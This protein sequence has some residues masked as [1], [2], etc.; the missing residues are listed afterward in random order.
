MKS[1][2]RSMAIIVIAVSLMLVGRNRLEM[3]RGV[4][5]DKVV[6]FYNWGDYIDPELLKQFEEETGY[7]VVYETFDSNEAMVTKIQQGG[8][9]YDLIGPSEYMVESMVE[10]G[11]LLPINKDLLP[12]LVNIDPKFMDQAYDPGNKYSIPYFWGTLG[13]LYNTKQIEEGEIKG[14]KDLWNEKYKESIMIYDGARE[15]MGIGLQS[16]GYSLNDTDY[17]HMVEA[18][19]KMKTLMPNIQALL[20]DEIKMYAVMEQAPIAV[21]FSGEAAMAMD[22]NE[23]LAYIIPEEGTNIWYDTLAIP[24]NAKNI[25]GAHALMD[26]LMRPEVAAQNAEYIGYA[27]PNAKAIELMDPEI[28]GDPAFYPSDELISKM[29]IYKNLGQENL[30]KYNDLYLEIKLEPR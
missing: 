22:D 8:T 13:I 26:F 24:K 25:E 2:L 21:T 7:V 16:L 11:L 28:T 18:K 27:T 3:T 17:S 1:L 19:K 30:I 9:N 5:G 4:T 20:A 6:N 12:N 10:Q 14:W 15:T 29:E 23:D